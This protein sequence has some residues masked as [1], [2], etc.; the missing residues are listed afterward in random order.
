M[1]LDVLIPLKTQR[2]ISLHGEAAGVWVG[3]VGAWKVQA[4]APLWRGVGRG[5]VWNRHVV[6]WV[7]MHCGHQDGHGR[8]FSLLLPEPRLHVLLLAHLCR[9]WIHECTVMNGKAAVSKT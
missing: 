8:G 3:G 1:T 7:V 5:L 4:V 2:S 6:D 9:E